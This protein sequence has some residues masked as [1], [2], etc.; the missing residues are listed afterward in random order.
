MYRPGKLIETLERRTL[1]AAN[2]SVIDVLA[3]YTPGALAYHGGDAGRLQAHFSAAIETANLALVNSEIAAVFRIVGVQPISYTGSNDLFLDRI[4]LTNPSDGFMD[5]AHTLRNTFGADLV[6]LLTEGAQNGGNASLP[7]NLTELNSGNF[8]FSANNIDAI[9]PG[10]L[11]LAHELGHNLGGGHERGNLIDPAVGPFPYSY[12]YRFT[13]SDGNLYHD[14]MSY[15]PGMVIYNYANPSVNF[16]GTPTGRPAGDAMSADIAAT[17]AQTIPVVAAFRPSATPD[18]AGPTA[19]LYSTTTAEAP[20]GA[21]RLDFTIRVADPAGVNAAT[22]DNNDV[23]VT[24]PPQFGGHMLHAGL[25]SIEGGAASGGGYKLVT[26]RVILPSRDIPLDELIY[27]LAA[28]AVADSFGNA[29]ASPAILGRNT[30]SVANINFAAARDLGS[31]NL[32]GGT[33]TVYES[34]GNFIGEADNTYRV[35]V[36]QPGTLAVQ[37]NG[38]TA[39]L[40]VFVARDLNGNGVYDFPAEAIAFSDNFAPTA[41][42]ALAINVTAGTYFVWTYGGVNTPYALAIRQYADAVAPSARVDATDLFSPGA[43]YIDFAVTYEDDQ[44]IDGETSRYWSAIDIR[45][46]LDNGADFTF[47]YYPEPAINTPYGLTGPSQTINYR[48]YPFN[49]TD[50]TSLENGTFTLSIHPNTGSDPRVRDAAG[51]DIPLLT[52]GAFRIKIGQSDTE[53]PSLAQLRAPGVSVPGSAAQLVTV[54]YRDNVALNAATFDSHDLRITGPGGFDV[55]ASLVA[56]GAAPAVGGERVVTYS[57]APPGGSWDVADRGAYTVSLQ[58][59]QVR[60]SSGNAMPAGALGV[61]D[62]VIPLPGDA[63]GNGSVTLDDFTALAANFGTQPRGIASGDFN[64]DNRVN[65]DDFTIL[66]SRF[67]SSLPAVALSRAKP[68][69]ARLESA[70]FGNIRLIDEIDPNHELPL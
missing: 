37:L 62:V 68:P 6:T 14:V 27:T 26:Y 61:F 35:T 46:Q 53:P 59:N 64:Y 9:Q 22:F 13:A 31:L 70:V 63:T 66:A 1:L 2:P 51:N 8:A 39:N 48:I 18:T 67:G 42:E 5:S 40:G 16:L 54:V 56:V 65:L 30:A 50:W 45:A 3:L 69:P 57:F 21:L 29:P 38:N 52:L 36:S 7:T 55:P 20:L 32:N 60:D 15:D 41:P 11:T 43:P 33:T 10:N 23:T 25:V 58:S 28:G 19:A 47:F 4:R 24:L 49:G 34:L 12:G 44:L 17:F